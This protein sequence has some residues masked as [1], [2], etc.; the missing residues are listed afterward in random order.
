MSY[1]HTV[2]N[3]FPI[4]YCLLNETSG[5]TATDLIS[6]FNGTYSS[7]P[8]NS[9]PLVNNCSNSK[10]FTNQT[11]MFSYLNSIWNINYPN[12]PFSIEFWISPQNIVLPETSIVSVGFDGVFIDQTGI[13]FKITGN[14]GQ[15]VLTAPINDYYYNNLHVVCTFDGSN[16]YIWINDLLINSMQFNDSIS[17]SANLLAINYFNSGSTYKLSNVSIYNKVLTKNMIDNDFNNGTDNSFINN[18]IRDVS[19]Y[20]KL[21]DDFTNVV[22]ESVEDDMDTLMNAFS[23]SNLFYNGT[24]LQVL[25]LSQSATRTTF[26]A[27]SVF[28]TADGSRIDWDSNSINFTVDISLDFGNTWTTNISNHSTIPGIGRSQSLANMGLMVRQNFNSNDVEYGE[29][30]YGSGFYGGEDISPYLNRLHIII[31]GNKNPISTDGTMQAIL[32]E[33]AKLIETVSPPIMVNNNSLLLGSGANMTI[34]APTNNSIYAIEMLVNVSS[35]AAINYILDART[36][37]ATGNLH[38]ATS[39]SPAAA[40]VVGGT[41]YV[42]GVL[43]T[44]VLA[45]FQPGTWVH[46]VLIPT[47]PI[48]TPIF[49]NSDYTGA[50]AGNVNYQWIGLYYYLPTASRILKHYQAAFGNPTLFLTEPTTQTVTGQ[51]WNAYNY[52]WGVSVG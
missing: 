21:D 34:P 36:V 23:I 27:I 20:Y 8:P 3:N 17:S 40:A 24:G 29:G 38:F 10:M 45:D 6:G 11:V 9:N 19:C 30:I 12:S 1:K 28:G 13:I 52:R 7:L 48:T 49:I 33:P 44:P 43:K 25:D 51:S 46:I 22:F 5:T 41:I 2:L 37:S 4:I 39:I 50:E 47:T 16:M 35:L 26:Y 15:Y 42:N 32:N 18:F 14:Q 31:Y